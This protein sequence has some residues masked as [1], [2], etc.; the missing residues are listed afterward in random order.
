MYKIV[1]MKLN[2]YKN[3]IV[4]VIIQLKKLLIQEQ[5]KHIIIVQLLTCYFAN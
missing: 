3:N 5:Y 1:Y 4:T 2:I